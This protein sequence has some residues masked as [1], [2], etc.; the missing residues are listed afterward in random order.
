LKSVE[1]G[2]SKIFATGLSQSVGSNISSSLFSMYVALSFNA[3]VATIGL[4][5]SASALTSTLVSLPSGILSDRFGR[6]PVIILGVALS[7]ISTALFFLASDITMLFIAQVIMGSSWPL[8]GP[9]IQALVADLAPPSRIGKA[10]GLYM[11]APS[12]GMFLGPLIASFLLLS[13]N[14]RETYVYSFL[15]ILLALLLAFLIASPKNPP[16]ESPKGRGS[17]SKAFKSRS[18]VVTSLACGSFFFVL[19]SVTT[20]YPLFALQHFQ[21]DPADVASIFSVMY[22]ASMMAR[23]LAV[24]KVN[25]RAAEKRLIIIALMISASVAL[26]PLAGGFALSA[27]VIALTGVAHGIIFPMGAMIIN[28]AAGPQERGVANSI[29]MLMVNLNVMLGPVLMGLVAQAWGLTLLFPVLAAA[30]VI[31]LVSSKYVP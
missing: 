22:F 16:K 30:S 18:V 24:S 21:A 6:K 8:F 25:S 14:I 29:F 15:V 4:L 2:F 26:L 12:V 10:V 17:F 1:K 9:S 11:I 19:Q 7:L 5:V 28:S 20:F 13:V 23:V 3:S 27:V 31:G